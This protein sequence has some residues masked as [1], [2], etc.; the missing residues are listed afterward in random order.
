[1]SSQYFL[2]ELS[3][4]IWNSKYRFRDETIVHDQSIEDTWRRVAQALASVESS[5]HALWEQRFYSIMEGFR[6]LPGGRILAGAGTSRRV[7]LFN[8]F[9]MGEVEDS[10]NGIFDA[11]KEAALTMQQGGGVGYDF[12]TLRPK[13]ELALS[14]GTIASGPVSFMRIWDSMCAT[15]LSSGAR[16]GAMMATLRCD[17]PDIEEFIEAKR[18][19]TQLRHFNLSVLVSDAFMRAVMQDDDWLLLFPLKPGAEHKGEIVERVWSGSSEAVPCK[20]TR[21]IR[22]R[23]LWDKIMRATY[24]YAEPGVIFIDRVNR[25]NNMW[26]AEHISATNPCG[27]IPLPAYGVCDLGSINLTA[28]VTAPF[29]PEAALDWEAIRA[30]VT[31][32]TRMLDNVYDLSHFPLPRQADVAKA[33]RRLGLG[34]T[35]LADAFIM[36]GVRYGSEQSL[37]LASEIMRQICHSAYR[38][39]IE[40][41]REKGVFPGFDHDKYLRGEFVQTLPQDILA[42][43]KDCGIRNSHLTAI[44]PAGTISLLANTISSGLEPVYEFNYLRRV[45]NADG[46]SSTF[47]VTDYAYAAYRRLYGEATPLSSAFI[48]ADDIPPAAHLAIQ[49]A[50]QTSVDHSISKTINVPQNFSFEAFRTIYEDAYASGLKGCTTFR[51]NPVTGQVMLSDERSLDENQCCFADSGVVENKIAYQG[52]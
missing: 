44:A 20:I 13:G 16:R 12:S 28:F 39:S 4:R 41:A 51:P 47:Q 50:L 35:G 1:M 45:Q 21:R 2:A 15:I 32:A 48:R 6:F 29:T 52:V 11:L 5:D 49:A 17:H 3:E 31:V 42:G 10:L 36:L 18:D 14:V 30:T 25:M 9:V 37:Q 24:D 7:T 27:E 22:A 23:V 19:R 46:S 38:A 26:Y 34:L 40:L 33:T 43:I 8:C